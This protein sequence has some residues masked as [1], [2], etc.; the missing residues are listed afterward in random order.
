MTDTV[1]NSVL[2]T[3]DLRVDLNLIEKR[4]KYPARTTVVLRLSGIM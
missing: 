4:A 2:P 1:R 3:S